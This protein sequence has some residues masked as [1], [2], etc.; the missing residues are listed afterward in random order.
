MGRYAHAKQYKRMRGALQKL[1]TRVGRVMR[2]FERQLAYL[3]EL[4]QM[5]AKQ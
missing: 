3:D 4:A 2:A 1:S 5:A